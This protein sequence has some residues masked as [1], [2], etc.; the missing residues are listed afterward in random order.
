MERFVIGDG[1]DEDT[2]D[3]TLVEEVERHL[4]ALL[5]DVLCGYLDPDLRRVADELLLDQPEPFEIRAASLKP[6]APEPRARPE[7]QLQGQLAIDD[8]MMTRVLVGARQAAPRSKALGEIARWGG[9]HGDEH[10]FGQKEM[11]RTLGFLWLVGGSTVLLSLAA[12]HG[13]DTNALG[14]LV[15]AVLAVF[16]GPL[17]LG[18]GH[19]LP[20][21][22]VPIF[23]VCGTTA[24]TS[25]V[26]FDGPGS[27]YAAFYL[28]VG[29]EA[30]LFLTRRG[31]ALQ[32]LS[33]PSPTAG[34]CRPPGRRTGGST[35]S[36]LWGPPSRWAA[37]GLPALAAG[38]PAGPPDR[39]GPH[40]RAD[41]D[42]QPARVR[43]ALRAG[44][45]PR[46]PRRPAAE[47]ADGRP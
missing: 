36:S 35:G 46:H 23:L 12:G 9:M 31:I 5:R 27:V 22:G 34:C 44:A 16:V 45:G 20:T 40:R 8:A 29:A 37:G 10:P 38:G 1:A 15:T 11:A 32:M 18:V 30:F 7:R 3:P 42:P 33:W 43:G 17:L 4:R 39:R 13:P 19:R 2:G 14:V 25:V 47:R 41:R 21:W 28:W 26:Y 24:I 6:A